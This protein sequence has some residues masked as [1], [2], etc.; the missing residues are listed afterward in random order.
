[1]KTK[2]IFGLLVGLMSVPYIVKATTYTYIEITGE[3]DKVEATTPTQAL[4]I[5]STN[6]TVLNS[7][8]TIDDGVIKED[9][10]YSTTYEYINIGGSLKSVE[11][12]GV[13]A[14][15]ILAYDI[16]PHSGVVNVDFSE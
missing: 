11:A 1:M 15:F 7:G 16:H 5:I 8:V 14:A 9:R 12:S 3:V 10:I 13:D 4:E 6:E 2:I